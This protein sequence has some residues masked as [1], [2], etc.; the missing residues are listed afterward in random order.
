MQLH[1]LPELQVVDEILK[2]RKQTRKVLIFRHVDLSGLDLS[3]LFFK[4]VRFE[5]CNLTGTCF[6]EADLRDSTFYECFGERPDFSYCKTGG[7]VFTRC[8][9]KTP[10][11]KGASLISSS[12]GNC[13][14]ANA[15]MRQSNLH[16]AKFRYSNFSFS[17]FTDANLSSTYWMYSSLFGCNL[18][19]ASLR[20]S[21]LDCVNFQFVNCYKTNIFCVL[22]KPNPQGSYTSLKHAK[23]MDLTGTYLGD[24]VDIC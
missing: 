20:D 2:H 15:D 3:C 16:N 19:D 14:F 5:Y 8:K 18:T 9:F 21:E 12:F 6:R 4:K 24:A 10:V 23:G 17:N 7:C 22:C 13:K 11:F 1:K